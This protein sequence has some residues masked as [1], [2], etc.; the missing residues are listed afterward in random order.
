MAHEHR[1]HQ[2]HHQQDVD[3]ASR[4]GA[5]ERD[6]DLFAGTELEIA[7]WL[8]ES[9][10]RRIVDVGCGVASMARALAVA[11]PVAEVTARDRTP[12]M[13]AAARRRLDRTPEGARVAVEP[14]DLDADDL[15]SWTADLIW[16][17]LVV[18]HVPDQIEGLRRLR[19]RLDPGGRIALGE[20]G[21]PARTLP[22]DIGVGRPGLEIRLDAAQNEWFTGMREGLDGTVASPIGWT[23]AL[24]QAGFTDVRTRSF[25][26]ELPVPLDDQ[27]RAAVV[28]RLR[29]VLERFVEDDLIDDD[30][31]A[32][33][34]AVT[35]E[36][37]PAFIGRRP[38]LQ[39]LWARSV[40]VGRVR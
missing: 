39:Y 40:H 20:G 29:L 7:R 16:A 38:D 22:W 34:E 18:H 35:D 1:P 27:A 3:W 23:A 5:M 2:H 6:A 14:I 17:S 13:L 11:F 26:V 12:E 10:A 36:S 21:L 33:L 15:G 4:I 28:D 19:D 30:D 31:T 25:L 9:P 24:E 37:S 32:T 8:A